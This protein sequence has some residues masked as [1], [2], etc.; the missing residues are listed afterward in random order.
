LLIE[1]TKEEFDVIPNEELTENGRL[2]QAK[3]LKFGIE[4]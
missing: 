3:L 2:L 4:G 1:P